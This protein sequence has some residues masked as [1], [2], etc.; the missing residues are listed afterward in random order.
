MAATNTNNVEKLLENTNAILE[1]MANSQSPIIQAYAEVATEGAKGFVYNGVMKPSIAQ[2]Y[3]KEHYEFCIRNLNCNDKNGLDIPLSAQETNRITATTNNNGYGLKLMPLY[4]LIENDNLY[5]ATPTEADLQDVAEAVSK[6]VINLLEKA[7]I[8]IG[9]TVWLKLANGDNSIKLYIKGIEHSIFQ[10]GYSVGI[11]G[12]DI[13]QQQQ[14]NSRTLESTYS[15]FEESTC[16]STIRTM[17]IG[18]NDGTF[19]I[20]WAEQ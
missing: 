10:K 7:H 20:Y 2:S 19:K 13:T 3:T 15:P 17:T 11:I 1:R 14:T 6:D 8:P 16:G 4:H 12:D 5:K 9:T 18:E